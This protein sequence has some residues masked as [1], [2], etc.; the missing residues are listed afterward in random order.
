MGR[1]ALEN[2]NIRK[3]NK[4]KAGS[5]L[6]TL[7]IELVREL[8]WRDKQKVVITKKGSKLVIEDWKR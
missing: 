2:K 4:T 3:I 7:P 1:R 6:V 8:K 5:V